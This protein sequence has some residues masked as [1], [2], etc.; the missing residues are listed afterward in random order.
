MGG[1]AAVAAAARLTKEFGYNGTAHVNSR[2]PSAQ[3]YAERLGRTEAL[4]MGMDADEDRVLGSEELPSVGSRLHRIGGCKP[5]AFVL[6]DEGCE[7]GQE[8]QF[9]HLC[10]PGEKKRR[11]KERL[12]IRRGS[13]QEARK[14]RQLA[15]VGWNSQAQRDLESR[16]SQ[17]RRV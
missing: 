9:C 14:Q 8:C 5:C 15:S 2:I 11:K 16:Q 13:R 1:F 12:M 17:T 10:D 3:A 4:P 7:N 6:S